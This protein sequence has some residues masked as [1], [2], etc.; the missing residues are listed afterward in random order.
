MNGSIAFPQIEP[1][2]SAH[3][4]GFIAF[5]EVWLSIPPL[6]KKFQGAGTFSGMISAPR[7][8]LPSLI[9]MMV[10]FFC[11]TCVPFG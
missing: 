10:M 6:A 3:I 2:L 11:G 9:S 1:I 7:V 8:Y 4:K 5:S